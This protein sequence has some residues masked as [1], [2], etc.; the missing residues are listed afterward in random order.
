LNIIRK[1]LF[2][3]FS[4]LLQQNCWAQVSQNIGESGGDEATYIDYYNNKIIATGTFQQ[5]LGGIASR[6]GS[7]VWL[8]QY[9]TLGNLLW[10]YTL[11]SS[12][13]EEVKGLCVDDVGNI[14]TTGEFNGTLEVGNDTLLTASRKSIFVTKHQA[15]G[16]LLWAKQLSGSG[17]VIVEDIA[18]APQ[19]QWYLTGAFR[20]SFEVD[21]LLLVTT[22][23]NAAFVAAFSPQAVVEW[24]TTSAY[25]MEALGKR[26]A[27][28]PNKQVYVAGEFKGLLQL[29]GDTMQANGIY[30]DLFLA[31][32]D[33]NGGW[34]WQKQLGG[35]YENQVEALLYQDGRL[36]LGGYFMGQ[37]QVD[38]LTLATADRHFDAFVAQLDGWGRVQWARQTQTS[39]DVLLQGMTL[40][41]GQL[42]AVGYYEDQVNWGD[43]AVGTATEIDGFGLQ[44]DTSGG[45]AFLINWSGG[46]NDLP[47]DVVQD[48]AGRQWVVGSFQQDLNWGSTVLNASGFSDGFLAVLET[49]DL[50]VPIWKIKRD[51]PTINFRIYPNPTTAILYLEGAVAYDYWQLVD[52][53]GRMHLQGQTNRIDLEPLTAGN[54]WLLV[55]VEGQVFARLVVKQ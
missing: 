29:V 54:Y 41:N 9:D 2:I 27:I 17:L 49:N 15:N 18:V 19:G 22:S 28:T 51:K 47:R 14:Y 48:A 10:Q 30:P 12:F 38:T 33:S 21:S 4:L 36:Y 55:V 45:K 32:L 25:S 3:Y 16:S 40:A 13:N 23:N 50:L 35:V 26:L 5:S 20:D 39:E 1:I 46:G 31:V 42:T 34:M 53:Q 7:D 43:A 6:G 44:I 11:G 8:Q 52:E 37:L 24:A